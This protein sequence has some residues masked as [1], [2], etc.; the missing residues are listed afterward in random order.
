MAGAL[1]RL[2]RTMCVNLQVDEAGMWR[3]L[4]ASRDFVLSEGVMLALAQ[5]VGKQSA[6]EIVYSTAMAAFEADRPLQEV[7]LEN[8]QI[9]AHLSP[10]EIDRLFDYRQQLGLCPEFVDRVVNMTECDRAGDE[11]KFKGDAL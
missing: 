8:E 1:L 4:E 5:K 3:N 6:H 7:V 10:A 2:A 9:T 11:I